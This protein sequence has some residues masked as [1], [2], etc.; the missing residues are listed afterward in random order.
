MAKRLGLFRSREFEKAGFPREY[1]RRLLRQG[2][3]QRIGHGLYCATDFDGDQNQSLLEVSKRF[4]RGVICLLSALRFHEI[5][6]QAPFEVW[7]AIST[8]DNLPRTA[9]RLAVRFCKF[10]DTTHAFGVKHHAVPGGEIPVYTP[11][12]TVADCFKYRN[13]F[14]VDIAVEA[15][16]EG[17]RQRK[18]TLAE[19]KEAAAVCR[20]A[21]VIQPYLEMLA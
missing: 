15:L 6:T 12:K 13:K 2:E 14:G 17:W 16:R 7:L 20:V 9:E 19:I 21:N 11:A 8:R 1:L 18:F 4:P 10:S 3:V 5:G